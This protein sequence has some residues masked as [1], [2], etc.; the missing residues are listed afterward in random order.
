MGAE[1]CAASVSGSGSASSISTDS[2]PGSL[3]NSGPR[4]SPIGPS[5]PNLGS[6]GRVPPNSR[7]SAVSTVSCSVGSALLSGDGVTSATIGLASSDAG[8]ITPPAL[9]A[10]DTE[11]RAGSGAGSATGIRSASFDA[12]PASAGFASLGNRGSPSDS[13]VTGGGNLGSEAAGITSAVSTVSFPENAA[14]NRS[15]S[16][17]ARSSN[18]VVSSSISTSSFSSYRCPGGGNGPPA[19]ISSTRATTRFANSLAS[20]AVPGSSG[21][22]AQLGKM[23]TRGLDPILSM[24]C[25][26][27]GST[28]LGFTP[29]RSA[30]STISSA[31]L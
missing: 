18:P 7:T 4:I 3:V 9:G 5:G 26:A 2:R 8:A 31:T 1:T 11:R 22:T 30:S 20:S 19:A 12:S 27:S 15:R 14:A 16:T 29:R 24:A 23:G 10:F 25:S 6:W 28:S 21:S 13:A 17:V